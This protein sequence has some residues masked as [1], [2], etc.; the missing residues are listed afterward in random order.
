M[1]HMVADDSFLIRSI[2]KLNRKIKELKPMV[3][4]DAPE[5][6]KYRTQFARNCARVGQT[7]QEYIQMMRLEEGLDQVV[8]GAA[9]ADVPAPTPTAEA[10]DVSHDH[11]PDLPRP[12]RRPHG[13]KAA[14]R[15][16][17]QAPG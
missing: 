3:D 12:A 7:E 17:D 13:R 16:D 9:V 14:Q 5:N 1:I 10:V 11:V 15:S 2:E 6:Q 8:P 4:F